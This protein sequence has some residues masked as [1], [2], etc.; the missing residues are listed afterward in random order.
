MKRCSREPLLLSIF[1]IAFITESAHAQTVGVY[2]QLKKVEWSGYEGD[3][4]GP[5]LKFFK[6]VFDE[7]H[8][9]MF[10]GTCVELSSAGSGSVDLTRYI[11]SVSV[12]KNTTT[13]NLIVETWEKRKDNSNS[14]GFHDDTGM[15]NQPDRHH[16][17]NTLPPINLNNYPIGKPFTYVVTNVEGGSSVKATI[18]LTYTPLTPT[19]PTGSDNGNN[20]AHEPYTLSTS[21]DG[22]FNNPNN[23]QYEWQ[24]N[25]PA[26]N[27]QFDPEPYEN[28]YT[29]CD[30]YNNANCWTVCEWIDDPPYTVDH[31][32]TIGFSPGMQLNFNPLTDLFSKAL[33]PNHQKVLTNLNVQFRVR[34]VAEARQSNWSLVSSTNFSPPAPYSNAAVLKEPSCVQSNT[35][36]ITLNNVVTPFSFY[37]YI[38]KKGNHDKLECNPEVANSCLV[39]VRSSGRN[40]AGTPVIITGLEKGDYSLFLLNDGSNLG[41]C[42]RRVGGLITIDPVPDL[43]AVLQTPA[44]ITC[45][46]TPTSS[47]SITTS[48]GRYTTV[49]YTLTNVTTGDV[50]NSSS[51]TANAAMSFPNLKAGK[52]DIV[53]SDGCTAPI[54]ASFTISQPVKIIQR[55]DLFESGSATCSSPGNGSARVFVERSGGAYDIS[56]SNTLVYKLL[57]DGQPYDEVETTNLV[58]TWTT[59]PPSPNYSLSIKEKGGADC[60]AAIKTFSIGGPLAIGLTNLS[61]TPVKCFGESNGQISVRGTGR[62]DYLY[63]ITGKDGIAINNT[64]GD[65]SSLKAGGYK[66]IIRNTIGCYDNYTRTDSVQVTQPQVLKAVV[67]KVD[68]SCHGLTDGKVS[69]TVTGGPV[70]T[71]YTYIWERFFDGP[72]AAWVEISNQTGAILSGRSDGKYRLRVKDDNLCDAISNEVTIIEPA[73]LVMSS[74]VVSDI[75]CIGEKGKITPVVTGGTAPYIFYYSINNW[76][77][78][79][80]FTASTLLDANTY[81]VK[82]KDTNGCE[83]IYPD[84]RL[85]TSPPEALSF[86]EQLS[87]FNGF[88]ISCYG[89][90]NGSA[91]ITATGGNGASYSGYTYAVDNRAFQNDVTLPGINAGSH[92]LKVKDARG[93][94]VTKTISFTQTAALLAEQ[95]IAKQDL[96]CFDGAT[97]FIEITGTGGN[98][99]Y[100]YSFDSGTFGDAG[101]FTQLRKGTYNITVKDR[102]GCTSSSPYELISLHPEI[103]IHPTVNNVS[104]FDGKDGAVATTV[105]GGVTPY[106]YQWAE[107]NSTASS[108]NDLRI[109]T[110]TLN[111]I[112]NVGCTMKSISTVSQPLQPLKIRLATVP[113]CYDRPNGSITATVTGGTQP[114]QYSI[115]NGAIYQ[116]E[117]AFSK[118]AGT[119]VVTTKDSKGCLITAST[120]VEVRNTM[121]EPNFL[122]AS[123]RNAKD[124]LAIIDISVPKP[125]SIHWKFDSQAIIVKNDPWTPELRFTDPGTY[126]VTMTGFFAGCDYSVT[127]KMTLSPYDENAIKETLPGYK[128]I[129]SLTATPNPSNGDFELYIKLTKKYKLSVV[130]FDVL[131]VRHYNKNWSDLEELH[132]RISLSDI[133]AGVY[134]LRA[135]TES[136]AQ[137]V[138]LVINK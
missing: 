120:T 104:C 4:H 78:S 105:V 95:L 73:L 29:D 5:R 14:C 134:M 17:V 137:D 107:V 11:G 127:K 75:A 108:I 66:L 13:L 1:L 60:N 98:A 128:P 43:N 34:I 7:Q 101:K 96:V 114:Y 28:C 25:L 130:I 41:V 100:Q 131:G 64:T 37:R 40:A 102:N 2:M 117:E 138:R 109:G 74:A 58:Y 26:E 47:I 61:I 136:D 48:G 89:G 99:P 122:V 97:G 82:V 19:V 32:T 22:S 110:Y 36:T 46:G 53:I 83:Y 57:K 55:D 94:V 113:V 87:D 63:Q 103:V 12:D 125:D 119:Y 33:D 62:T 132:E 70:G 10:N 15:F 90:S 20:C 67:S 65:F 118:G 8:S 77:T 18:E 54:P 71:Q 50:Y 91:V 124:T 81:Q 27:V 86:I 123:A 3:K 59:L 31:W 79:T 39:D 38:L 51:A 56:V 52:H 21:I 84:S 116:S 115:D 49:S 35:G 112:D 23:I 68:I 6:D 9:T 72:N 24:F 69:A 88:N 133:P 44:T 42:P 80:V 129:E 93:C 76:T 106:Q 45:N 135:I 121:P 30:P 92:I 85:I 111:L 16:V 126:S